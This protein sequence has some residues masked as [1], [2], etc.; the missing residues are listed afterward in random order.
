MTDLYASIADARAEVIGAAR[1]LV[2]SAQ[3]GDAA[4]GMSVLAIKLERLDGLRAIAKE[5]EAGLD[6][7]AT[8]PEGS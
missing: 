2:E 1:Y 8:R 4:L 6:A 3:D 5:Y 7:I